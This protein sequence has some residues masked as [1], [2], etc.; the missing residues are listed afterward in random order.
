MIQSALAAVVKISPRAASSTISVVSQLKI[1]LPCILLTSLP[2]VSARD[3]DT[4]ILVIHEPLFQ[5]TDDLPALC[6]GRAAPALLG[7]V[8]GRDFGRDFL[9]AVGD[10]SVEMQSSGR[11]VAC[12]P[13]AVGGVKRG[14]QAFVVDVGFEV[15]V[16]DDDG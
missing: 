4:R 3:L 11:V 15:R 10:D 14:D 5:T 16:S 2:G 7:T 8:C 6:K 9:A 1:T 13:P 12:D